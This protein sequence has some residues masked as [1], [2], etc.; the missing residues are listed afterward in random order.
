MSEK[1]RGKLPVKAVA[2]STG[3]GKKRAMSSTALKKIA[4]T[5]G[6]PQAAKAAGIIPEKPMKTNG[7]KIK[8]IKKK[9]VTGVSK[10]ASSLQPVTPKV[11]KAL[12]KRIG[13]AKINVMI[14]TM[15]E[16]NPQ[17][18]IFKAAN[19]QWLKEK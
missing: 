2:V 5:R 9:T 12:R 18:K 3:E 14:K 13:D 1:A 16:T 19:A 15:K 6:L 17:Y 7:V 10:K 4:E 11:V 8:P